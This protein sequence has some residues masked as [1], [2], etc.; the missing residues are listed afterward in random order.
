MTYDPRAPVMKSAGDVEWMA[1][2]EAI[3]MGVA[4][5]NRGAGA[6]GSFG[7]FPPNFITPIH[8]HSHPYHAIVLWGTMTNPMGANGESEP[9]V[10]GPGSYW[11]VPAGEPHA[12]ACIS[13]TPCQ[14]YFHM[15]H[16]FDFQPLEG[17]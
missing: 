17:N 1:L 12:T 14:F 5:G 10:L 16:A 6:H 2:N 8:K 3:S 15:E 13:S 11:Y 4:Y 7:S 9:T